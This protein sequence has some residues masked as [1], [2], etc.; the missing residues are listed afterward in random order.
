MNWKITGIVVVAM[1]SMIGIG[2]GIYAAVKIFRMVLEAPAQAQCNSKDPDTSITGC[3]AILASAKDNKGQL[4][5]AHFQ[6]ALAYAN[7]GNLDGAIADDTEVIRL[8]PRQYMAWNH[9]GSVFERKGQLD[10]AI[11]DF[12]QAIQLMPQQNLSRFARAEAYS[13]KGNYA[14]AIDDLS[15]VLK[16]EPKNSVAW[17]NRCYFRAIAG[18]LEAALEDCNHSLQLLPGVSNTLDSRG[19]TYLRMKKYDLAIADYDAA[20]AAGGKGAPWLYGRG[21]ARRAK[22]DNA[23]ARQDIEEALKLDPGIAATFRSY[24]VV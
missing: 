15:V 12:T 8:N 18:Q 13:K 9:R 23:G 10:P 5:F 11:A 7:K 19:F 6:R 22:H 17:N 16:R 3:S 2:G 1:L 14:A 21:L 20:I 4:E 24:G